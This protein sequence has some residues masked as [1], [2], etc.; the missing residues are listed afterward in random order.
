SRVPHAGG[1]RNALRTAQPTGRVGVLTKDDRIG[2]VDLL[3]GAFD[4]WMPGTDFNVWHGIWNAIYADPTSRAIVIIEEGELRIYAQ[5]RE[6]FRAQARSVPESS[7]HWGPP[8]FSSDGR[9]V[10]LSESSSPGY[11]RTLETNTWTEVASVR[12]PTDDPEAFLSHDGATLFVDS[13]REGLLRYTTP[14]LEPA[15]TVAPELGPVTG[16]TSTS[17]GELLVLATDQPGVIHLYDTAANATLSSIPLHAT[18][19][20]VDPIVSSDNRIAAIPLPSEEGV[21]VL[22]LTMP[23]DPSR[24]LL[25]GHES[26]VYQLAMSPDGSLL[27]SAEPVGDILLWDLRADRLLA[28]LPR[29]SGA[30]NGLLLHNMD[31]PLV[32][33]NDGRSLVFGELDESLTPGLTVINLES[34]RRRWADTGSHKATLD[35]VAAM[36]P[37]GTP[38][39]LY[40]HAALLGNGKLVHSHSGVINGRRVVVRDPASA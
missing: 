12:T 18:R 2:A 28:R 6:V 4:E 5:G 27:A 25:E 31:T 1:V 3:T 24:T 35:A 37:A 36:L 8:R 33:T 10:Y 11:L 16:A 22:D 40:H 30:S 15:G 14:M 38:A 23:V 17:A 34:G 32:F 19:L 39:P 21:W 7:R 26:W 9:Y 13:G 29:R 20:L